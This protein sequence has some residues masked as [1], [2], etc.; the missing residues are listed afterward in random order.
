[1]KAWAWLLAPTLLLAGCTRATPS[2]NPDTLGSAPPGAAPVSSSGRAPASAGAKPQGSAA[3]AGPGAPAAAGGPQTAQGIDVGTPALIHVGDR[4]LPVVVVANSS[5]APRSFTVG[6]TW[7]RGDA[8]AAAEQG[9][10]FALQPGE[11][12]VVNLAS[13]SGTPADGETAEAR[14]DRVLP[15]DQRLSDVVSKIQFGRT[16][17]QRG[18]L[19][20]LEV[21]VTNTDAAPHN[22]MLGGALLSKGV[23]IATASGSATLGPRLGLPVMLALAGDDSGFDQVLAYVTAVL[24]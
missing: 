12:R 7:K 15:L 2:V 3:S 11:T 17:L 1:V 5:G 23:P 13:Q 9:S 8:A 22:L 24:S 18:Q 4:E 20:S 16:V 19:S 10:V 6:A 14:V 21:L